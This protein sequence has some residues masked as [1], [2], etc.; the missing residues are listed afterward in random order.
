MSLI[1]KHAR[2]NKKLGLM[3]SMYVGTFNLTRH[4]LA[5]IVTLWTFI[6]IISVIWLH[7]NVV[8]LV[9]LLFHMNSSIPS[10]SAS[11]LTIRM[12]HVH[13]VVQCHS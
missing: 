6:S 7:N 4:S 8:S 11:K 10:D 3:S 13:I 1:G 2:I 9:Y 5:N 12:I